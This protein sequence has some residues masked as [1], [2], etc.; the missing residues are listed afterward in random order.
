[1][2]YSLLAGC[3][4]LLPCLPARGRFHGWFPLWSTGRTCLFF[5]FFSRDRFTSL[6]FREWKTGARSQ[7]PYE[8]LTVTGVRQL[9]AIFFSTCRA[10]GHRRY[11][12]GAVGFRVNTRDYFHFLGDATGV[13]AI[14]PVV[15]GQTSW[16]GFVGREAAPCVTPRSSGLLL[17]KACAA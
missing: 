14:P 17:M 5:F 11:H 15:C 2:R 6:S 1:M 12:V 9:L 10:M 16:R 13:E 4:L 8:A 7:P 3:L